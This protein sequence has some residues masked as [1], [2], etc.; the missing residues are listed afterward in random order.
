[1]RKLLALRLL[2]VVVTSERLERQGPSQ[3][4]VD[5]HQLHERKFPLQ[6]LRVLAVPLL[7]QRIDEDW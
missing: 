2:W 4:G 1:M 7:Q 6:A 3:V 5:S